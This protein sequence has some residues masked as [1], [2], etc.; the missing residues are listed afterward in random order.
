MNLGATLANSA[1]L[2]ASLPAYRPFRDA[3]ERPGE[4]QWR[5][6]RAGLAR[7]AATAYGRAHGFAEIGSYAEF[8]RRVPIVDHAALAPWIARIERGEPAVLTRD[9]VTRLLPT[10]GS[11]AARKL[12]PFTAALQNE[13][14]AAIGAWLVDLARRHPAVIAGRA[15]WALT[16]PA[17]APADPAGVIPIGFDEDSRH[18]GGLR[19]RLVER[20]MAVPSLVRL[21]GDLAAFRIGVL[22]H[23]V[24]CPDLRLVSVWHPSF[25][26]LLLDT[27]VGE[28]DA[29]LA[30]VPAARARALRRSDPRRPETIWPALRVVSCWGDALAAGPAADLQRR[31]PQAVVEPKGLLAT[32]AFVSVPCGGARPLAIT[33]HF[34]EF[35]QDDGRVVPADALRD[36]ETYEVVVTT[37]GGLWRYRLGDRVRVEGRVGRTAAIRF[38]GRAGNVSDCC[39]EKLAEEFVAGVL[40]ACCGGARFAM[41]APEAD[42]AGWRYALYLDAAGAARADAARVEAALRANPHYALCRDLGQLGPVRLYPVA[43]DAYEQFVAAEAARGR[44][45]GDIKPAALSR[46]TDWSARF[47]FGAVAGG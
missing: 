7:H 23:L 14:N 33:S 4:A 38:L 27:L 37:G 11:S 24:A 9:P 31:L 8:A 19:A 12:I 42:A 10:S 40:A 29:V 43:G 44:R 18:L 39:G 47:R 16:P 5:L 15:Y 20:S 45:I 6:L 26:T 35:I 1:W 28:W 21:I 13:F 3:L 41:L 46:R 2:A 25:F 34:L 17:K 30:A 36:G 22:R 32:E